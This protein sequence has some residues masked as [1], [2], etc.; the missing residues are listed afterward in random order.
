MK[1]SKHLI[2]TTS[3]L[4]GVLILGGCATKNKA[5]EEPEPDQEPV[6]R[7]RVIHNAQGANV[8][9]MD[10]PELRTCVEHHPKN[11]SALP[12]KSPRHTESHLGIPE[13]I[14][15][16]RTR[17]VEYY[18][19]P[20]QGTAIQ[21]SLEFYGSYSGGGMT[22]YNTSRCRV[23][24]S[25]RPEAGKDY[26]L[27]GDADGKSCRAYLVGV[28]PLDPTDSGSSGPAKGVAIPVHQAKT[29]VAEAGK[30]FEKICGN[31]IERMDPAT[32]KRVIS[33]GPQN[34][35]DQ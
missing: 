4:I 31:E 22:F 19:R 35:K 25:F 28:A 33:P 1:K 24:L 12:Q 6:A 30:E 18:I 15:D 7:L 8:F 14:P 17:S 23:T 27:R 26:E 2:Q 32:G 29:E 3:L 11:W 10:N 34:K 21:V 20:N 5:Y 16:S 13:V 9:L